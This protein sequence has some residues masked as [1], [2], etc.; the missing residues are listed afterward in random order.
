MGGLVG[1]S[2]RRH[3]IAA[4][5]ALLVTSAA[6]MLL[7]LTPEAWVDHPGRKASSQTWRTSTSLALSA[8]LFLSA[9]LSVGPVRVL[10]GR[11][12]AVH[13][14]WRRALGVTGAVLAA[15]HIV[16]ALNV[17]GSLWRAWEQFFTGRPTLDDPIVI[18]GGARGYA[19][20]L[21]L[22]AGVALLGLAFVSRTAWL[23]RLGAARWK[24]AQRA[25]YLVLALVALHALLYWRV[26][27]R[28]LLHR[29]MVLAPIIGTVILQISAA[30]THARRRRRSGL[31]EAS[32]ALPRSNRYDRTRPRRRSR[33]S[34]RN[35]LANRSTR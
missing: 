14:P 17:H 16:V 29:A 32:G 13:L 18:R 2:T 34:T 20:Y 1:P 6:F 21:G 23:R 31:A 27:R 4:A 24:T 19:N 35:S 8:V 25:T 9:T 26:E 28:L 5:L 12:P 11:S 3:R 33:E 30:A 7:R 22:L 10:R 15:T